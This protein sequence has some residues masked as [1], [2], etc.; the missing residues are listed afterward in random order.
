MEVL[1]GLELLLEPVVN[2]P[3]PP[4]GVVLLLQ[5]AVV[6]STLL[7][8]AVVKLPEPSVDGN[9]VEAV[10]FRPV[11]AVS[12]ESPLGVVVFVGDGVDVLPPS[13][14]KFEVKVGVSMPESVVV[15]FQLI[16]L[17]VSEGE[18]V[19][20]VPLPMFVLVV[21]ELNPPMFVLSEGAGVLFVPLPVSVLVVFSHEGA[22]PDAVPL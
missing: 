6:G 14:V 15:E 12:V 16:V 13:P 8:E 3:E 9:E 1:V 17:V 5:D 11:D 21:V 20:V 2:V 22:G 19:P 18:G 7:F 10:E 4:V